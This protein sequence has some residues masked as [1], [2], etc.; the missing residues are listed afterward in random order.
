MWIFTKNAALS[1]VQYDPT[2]GYADDG[3]AP[4]D[5]TQLFVRGRR[6]EH[7]IDFGFADHEVISTP[8]NDYPFRVLTSRT[9]VSEMVAEQVMGINYENYKNAAQHHMPYG[10]LSAIWSSVRWWLDDRS[11]RSTAPV[12]FEDET[13]SPF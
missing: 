4:K 3:L 13:E 9:R 1:I 8:D 10:M 6:L 7:L 2:N 11:G 12:V 5:D